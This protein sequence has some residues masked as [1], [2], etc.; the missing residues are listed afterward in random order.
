MQWRRSTVPAHERTTAQRILFAVG[1]AWDVLSWGYLLL[2]LI[3]ALSRQIGGR[4]PSVLQALQAGFPLLVLGLPVVLLVTLGTRR[5]LAASIAAVLSVSAWLAVRP[6]MGTDPQPFWVRNAVSLRVTE[7]NVYFKNERNDEVVAALLATKAD[8]IVVAEVTDSFVTAAINEGFE[9]AY[10]YRLVDSQQGTGNSSSA[11]GL[12]LYSKFPIDD[13]IRIGADR[14][15][16][17]RLILPG[18]VA[19]RLGAVHAA[20]PVNAAAVAEWTKDLARLGTLVDR[21]TEPLVFVGDFNATR[22]QP[23]FGALLGRGLTDAHESMGQGLSRSW[24]TR[25]PLFRLDHALTTRQVV[26]T[27]LNDLPIPGSDHIGFV[28]D[29]A[30]Q[31][32]Q[33]ETKPKKRKGAG[34]KPAAASTASTASTAG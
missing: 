8:V 30:V 6:A 2:V 3:V 18:G 28:A 9:N 25:F 20:A 13:V 33:A 27:K 22:W 10:P 1:G 19:I 21:N 12:G 4:A 14:A 23:S 7:A 15:P 32:K 29:L 17:V 26:A 11:G 5:W 24:P 31:T 16:F 34:P